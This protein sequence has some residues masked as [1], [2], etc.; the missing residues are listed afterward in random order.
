MTAPA[1]RRRKDFDDD[2]FAAAKR[3]A[4]ALDQ[5]GL[6]QNRVGDDQRAFGAEPLRDLAEL[7]HGIAAEE[8]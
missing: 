1:R 3:L 2:M 7:P 6:D 8:S 5:A 4:D